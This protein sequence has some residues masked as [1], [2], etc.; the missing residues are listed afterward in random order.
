MTPNRRRSA[1]RMLQGRFGVS[2]RRACKVTGQSRSTQRST[3]P[4]TS[5][6]DETLICE[7]KRFALSH[8]PLGYKRAYRALIDA[9]YNVNLKR[10]HRLWREAGL[11]VPYKKKRKPYQRKGV[12]MG[13]HHPTAANV[14]WAMDFQFDQ[15]IDTAPIKILNITDEYSREYLTSIAARSISAKDVL[16]ALDD[17]LATRDKPLYLS[18]RSRSRVSG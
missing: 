16:A 4:G 5:E 15:S 14:C 10:V 6:L 7:L 2:E 1:T 11:K 8:P 13:S 9:G 18:G 3:P 17:L 12:S